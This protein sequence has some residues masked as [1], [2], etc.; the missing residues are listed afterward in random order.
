[1]AIRRTPF[2]HGENKNQVP[3]NQVTSSLIDILTS[4]KE[5]IKQVLTPKEN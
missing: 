3:I 1:M 4:L 2:I 5:F